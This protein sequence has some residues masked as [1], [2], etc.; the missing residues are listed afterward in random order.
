[1]HSKLGPS[2]SAC[3][4]HL[5]YEPSSLDVADPV[6]ST[7]LAISFLALST[8]AYESLFV[9]ACSP[10]SSSVIMSPPD[11][12]RIAFSRGKSQIKPFCLCPP[13]KASPTTHCVYEHILAEE[14]LRQYCC[15]G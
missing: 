4:E 7:S 6:P 12:Y 10:A 9:S 15:E 3:G 8:S 11:T 1:M 5:T 2:I 13:T 14:Q